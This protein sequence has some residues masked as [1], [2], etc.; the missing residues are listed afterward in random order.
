[1]QALAGAPPLL[2]ATK[3]PI[4]LSSGPSEIP[5]E[6]QA[7]MAAEMEQDQ[8]A[9]D[10]ELALLKQRKESGITA[11]SVFLPLHPTW[12][13]RPRRILN[14]EAATSLD[15]TTVFMT[16]APG[17]KL[18]MFVEGNDGP[19]VAWDKLAAEHRKRAEAR[20]ARAE[21]LSA[22]HAAESFAART[23]RDKAA[24]E[25]QAA[26]EKKKKKKATKAR[27]KAVKMESAARARELEEEAAARAR[28]RKVLEAEEL[29]RGRDRSQ[30]AQAKAMRDRW[31][32]YQEFC[33][34]Q[35][36]AGG[37]ETGGSTGDDSS[38]DDEEEEEEE[39]DVD[40]NRDDLEEWVTDEIREMRLLK[41]AERDEAVQRI[42]ASRSPTLE[43]ALGIAQLDAGGE[44]ARH[45]RKVLRLLHPDFGI[46]QKL[47]GK[48]QRHVE[49]AF[50]RLN[51]L[52]ASAQQA[53]G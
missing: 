25:R 14:I 6:M 36:A 22:K 7:L 9:A 15:H 39:E 5:A 35:Q 20:T 31:K 4:V 24:T 10:E 49:R 1:M 27:K 45:V 17:H 12:R 18:P 41:A 52:W 53:G 3:R 40:G 13:H 46:N 47:G 44:V 2:P 26:T 43:D 16:L 38:S 21:Q 29:A 48:H 42:L 30:A 32:A 34:Q 51:G 11:K 33:R 28:M 37:R 23:R 8:R 50:K 19:A